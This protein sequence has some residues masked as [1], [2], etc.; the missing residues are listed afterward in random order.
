MPTDAPRPPIW[1]RP[2]PSARAPRF[3]RERIAAAALE[4]ADA[5]GIAAV[6]MRNVAARLGAGTMTLYNYVETKDELF[7]LMDDALM[8]EAVVPADELPAG[9]REATAEIARRTWTVLTRHPWA[10]TVGQG[11]AIGPNAMLHFE[12][13]LA[14]L[15]GTGLDNAAKLDLLAIVDA[16]VFGSALRAA[17]ARG[18]GE[19]DPAEVEAIVAYGMRQLHTGRFPHTAALLGGR[20]PRDAEVAGPPVDEAGVA[21]QF[22]RGLQAVLDG[23]AAR[24]MFGV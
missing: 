17:D 18:R 11:P 21:A 5:E 13:S 2:E 6:S 9:W 7:A 23:V 24:I 12:Q 14:A 16:Y 4:I 10:I 19:T 3:S 15:A 8:A 1:A 22:E 20:D